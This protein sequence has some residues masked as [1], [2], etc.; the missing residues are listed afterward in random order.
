MVC[1][2]LDAFYGGRL[3]RIHIELILKGMAISMDFVLFFLISASVLGLLCLVVLEYQNS[4]TRKMVRL[5]PEQQPPSSADRVRPAEPPPEIQIQLP[6]PE[7]DLTPGPT[8]PRLTQKP[9][10]NQVYA[11]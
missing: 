2:L 6:P 5:W 9:P 3:N 11:K 10:K 7:K 1:P 4:R 8:H